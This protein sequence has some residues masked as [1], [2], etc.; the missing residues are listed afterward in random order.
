MRPVGLLVRKGRNALFLPEPFA[1]T[2]LIFAEEPSLIDREIASS[3]GRQSRMLISFPFLPASND[4]STDPY[5]LAALS[6][7]V[8]IDDYESV[9]GVYPVSA[10]RRWHGGIHLTP[11]LR[12]EPVRAIADGT[13]V[14][15]RSTSELR[16]GFDSSFIL[17]K[18]ETETGGDR[19]L[20]FYSLYMH[21]KSH[22]ALKVRPMQLRTVVPFM[23][24]ATS[25]V[26]ADGET[27]VYR[28]DILGYPGEMYGHRMIH[29]EIFMTDVDFQAYFNKT[30]L[31]KQSVEVDGTDELWGDVYFVIP[32]ASFREKPNGQSSVTGRS[33]GTTFVRISYD[34]VV[35]YT[36]VWVSREPG[37]A[38]TLITPAD[39][40]PETEYEYSL[41]KTAC[42]RYPA[43]PSAGYEL[44]RFGRVL[45]PDKGKLPVEQ[46][47]NWQLIPFA[48]GKSGYIDLNSPSI[49]TLSDADFPYFKGW[50]KV[51][52]ES[53][54]LS[55]DGLCDVEAIL[56]IVCESDVPEPRV[57]VDRQER[58]ALYLS[59]ADTARRK[60]RG[61]IC[62]ASTEWDKTTNVLRFGGLTKQG[63]RFEGKPEEL[64][65]FLEFVEQF[66][67]W[68]KTGLPTKI[69]HF[70]PLA[71]I[72]HFRKCK[73]LSRSELIQ[74]VPVSAAR[75]HKGGWVSEKV[76]VDRTAIEQHRPD[77]NRALRKFGILSPERMAA[78]FGNA[79]QE[80][81]WFGKL[82]EINSTAWYYP[83]DGRGFMQLT[84]PGNYIKYWRWRG[85]D[86][87]I[88]IEQ[89]LVAAYGKK[90]HAGLQDS[91]NPGLTEVMIQWRQDL[92]GARASTRYD[93][94][95]SA[96]SYW[97]WSG[98][99][100]FADCP[101]KYEYATLTIDGQRVA[102]HKSSSF[103][104]VA[105][106]V[107]FG[108][109]VSN[110]A[111]I[112]KVNG[113]VARYQA[114]ACALVGLADTQQFPTS[115]G[116]PA[117]LPEGHERRKGAL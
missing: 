115:D 50:M 104:Q 41:F 20:T 90:D 23:Q 6:E 81:Q 25:D 65:K 26:R 49:R 55:N 60:L 79:M 68:D 78:F 58:L 101:S 51:S 17:L 85:R 105:A 31:G 45:G 21:L 92:A 116:T 100:R 108:S 14:A 36:T 27:K 109:P 84:G 16:E 30:Q 102:Y 15:Y 8:N 19:P 72:G 110:L 10:G 46:N 63:E 40:I 22:K 69:W 35:K 88:K 38:L 70:H 9:Y 107:N 4:N 12:D 59:Q 56:D 24:T 76:V 87:P 83:W 42:D 86:V 29:F 13:V 89:P 98:A 95:D 97:A 91:R 61:M 82:Y 34:K 94:A 48:E 99:A 73:W 114:N 53:G 3:S 2:S 11:K 32:A 5:E 1:S 106:T 80:T 93:A 57:G 33:E 39:G 74:L 75:P 77:L 112:N 62:E 96:A 103:G 37:N 117:S 64:Q 113:I 18:H 71:F 28:K 52:E 67:F 111:N 44:L 66:Q 43:C 54:V 7:V 47:V